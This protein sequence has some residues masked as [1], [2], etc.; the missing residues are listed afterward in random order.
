MNLYTIMLLA[1]SL[2]LGSSITISSNHWI[3]AWLGLEI[4]TLAIIPLMVHTYHPRA[5]EAATKYFL[6]QATASALLIFSCTMNAWVTGEWTIFPHTETTPVNLLAIALMMKIGIVPFHFW[7]PD[8]MQGISLHAGLILSTWQKLPPMMLLLEVSS[9]TN[10]ELLLTLGILSS[11]VGGWGGL[12]QTQIRKLLAYSSITHLGWMITVSKLS[13]SLTLFSFM[14]YALITSTFFMALIILNVK[15]IPD[16]STAWSK[17]PPITLFALLLLLSLGGL[18]PLTGFLPKLLIAQ[19]LV[20]EDLTLYVIMLFISSLLSL[21]F[22]LRLA[23]ILTITMS[24]H[25]FFSVTHWL[26]PYKPPISMV[27]PTMMTMS[28]FLTPILPLISIY[29]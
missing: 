4:N 16:F 2:L 12:N 23:Y 25:P 8:V 22:Y 20:N 28:L 29:L 5:I 27:F 1:L 21:F 18:P 3:L 13:P 14:I 10:L 26:Y 24:P 6:T 19:K 15:T 11:I 9:S 17:S 7:L